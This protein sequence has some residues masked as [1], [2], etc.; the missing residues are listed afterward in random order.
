MYCRM[1]IDKHIT[2]EQ[3]SMQFHGL[4]IEIHFHY[5]IAQL[6]DDRNIM[7]YNAKFESFAHKF[8]GMILRVVFAVHNVHG[9]HRPF[10]GS[11]NSILKVL[12]TES[13]T[14]L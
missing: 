9:R 8:D 13:F 10:D 14:K 1:L 2:V 4:K 11:S 12:I 7:Y 5:V 6:I 3:P